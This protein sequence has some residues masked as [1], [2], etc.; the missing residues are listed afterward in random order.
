MKKWVN[1]STIYNWTKWVNVSTIYNDKMSEC[2][3]NL[4]LG[5]WVN[6]SIIYY[7]KMSEII[8]NLQLKNEW[9][10]P[11][12]KNEWMHPQFTIGTRA[13]RG[14]SPLLK[15]WPFDLWPWKS[16]GLQILLKGLSMRHWRMV[17]LECYGRTDSSVT[18][19]ISLRNFVSEE[20]KMSECI[21]NLQ[22]KNEWMH[23]QFTIGKMSECIPNLQMEK[24]GECI[25]NLQMEKIGECIHNL[26][27]NFL[28]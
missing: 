13:K 9:M 14:V 25:H 2:I 24:I 3:H 16:I 21:H 17:I 28:D 8:H 4:Q 23:P 27:K 6:A 11:Q 18:T 7:W 19:G 20:I 22:L 12:L 10:H 5:K 26:Q 15:I 1:A